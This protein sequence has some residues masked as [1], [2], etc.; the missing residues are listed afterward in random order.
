MMRVNGAKIGDE[1]IICTMFN[2][3]RLNPQGGKLARIYVIGCFLGTRHVAVKIKDSAGRF[4]IRRV[5]AWSEIDSVKE[6]NR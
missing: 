1:V 5:Y 6:D 4:S 2:D 3:G